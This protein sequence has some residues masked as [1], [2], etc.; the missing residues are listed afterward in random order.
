MADLDAIQSDSNFLLYQSD[1]GKLRIEV[2]LQD[3][4]VWLTQNAMMELFESSKSNISEHIK[5]VFEEGELTE[6]AVVRN[7]RTTASDG[8]MYDVKHN[9]LD[10][11]FSVFIL[12]S[13]FSSIFLCLLI[14]DEY[15]IRNDCSKTLLRL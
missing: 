8:K 7:F 14:F 9:N 13:S 5:H 4:T 12:F 2:R 11:I 15:I 6:K 1:D 3:E 10:V